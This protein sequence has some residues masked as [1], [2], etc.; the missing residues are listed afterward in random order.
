MLTFI[1]VIALCAQV[2]MTMA[3]YL[4]GPKRFRNRAFAMLSF[5]L[6]CWAALNY[7]NSLPSLQAN[8]Y[9]MRFIMFFVVLQNVFFVMF[10]YS[11]WIKHL[12]PLTKRG[13][14]YVALSILTVLLALS[15]VLFTH[16]NQ[17]PRGPYPVPG[18]GMV[19]FIVHAFISIYIGFRNLII[20]RRK[21]SPQYKPQLAFITLGSVVLWGFVPL[22][23]FILSLTLQTSF[24]IQFSPLY[25]FAFSSLIAYAIIRHKLFDIRV[26]VI[27]TLAYIFSTLLLSLVYIV[28]SILIVAAVMH[29]HF[30]WE[31]FIIGIVVAT[32]FALFYSQ[33]REIFN[34][35]TNRVF[36][37][38]YYEP[39]EV[40][41]RLSE[42]LVRSIDTDYIKR[43]SI[44]ILHTAIKT[45]QFS[46]ALPSKT[47][48]EQQTYELL[49]GLFG[50]RT[51]SNVLATDEYEGNARGL[52]YTK[53]QGIAL[54]VRL[55]TGD[56]VLGFLVLG[57][58][59]SGEGYSEKDR[60]LL[61]IAADEIAISLQNALHFEETQH[62]NRRLQEKVAEAT[63]ELRR[64]NDKLK[65]LD[66]TKDDFISMASHQLRTPL[67]SVKGY[68][69]LVLEGDAGKLNAQQRKLLTQSFASSQRM[70]YLISDLLNV[71]RLR[72]G[73]FVIEATPVNLADIITDEIEQ[74]K[75]TA[76]TRELTLTYDKPADFPLLML[77]ET[78]TRQVIMNYIDNAI[79]YTPSGGH[80]E[81]RLVNKPSAVELRVVDDGIGVPK[82]EQHHLFTKFY[83]A[84]NARKA[85]PDGTGLGLFMAKKV[86]AAQ[87]GAVIFD[88]QENKGS[89]FGFS[90]SKAKLAVPASQPKTG[91]KEPAATQ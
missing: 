53:D 20:A 8:L 64:T 86:I 62:F 89:T 56:N 88:S 17:G 42:M 79:Y 7:A 65:A 68:L 26:F 48:D 23:N 43:Q 2:I 70:V 84:G 54:V 36:F 81:V 31:R 51:A 44:R 60:R 28:P 71:S 76:T 14:W 91:Q 30:T 67:T 29:I 32:C 40:L 45:N 66:E 15:P 41:D 85:R 82:S 46:Y 34:E 47:A 1:A 87:G 6:V 12:F 39:Q 37:R 75:E 22:T 74:L 4:N 61:S 21:T 90:F 55:R 13:K 73:K 63:K 80:I 77:D 58:K 25:A 69:S 19:F 16:V 57:Y 3:V 50:R 33:V 18:P 35:I 49:A 52:E 27:R 11:L 24:F 5:S 83:R 10:S 59:E 9:L 78:K 72:T 38:G